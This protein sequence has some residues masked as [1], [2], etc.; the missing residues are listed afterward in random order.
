MP[1]AHSPDISSLNRGTC[2]VHLP[3]SSILLLSLTLAGVC[4]Q[5][6]DRHTHTGNLVLT[7]LRLWWRWLSLVLLEHYHSETWLRAPSSLTVSSCQ[8]LLRS[9]APVLHSLCLAHLAPLVF[10]LAIDIIIV[11]SS[12]YLNS[13]LTKQLSFIAADKISPT[14]VWIT[15]TAC[16]LQLATG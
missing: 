10:P 11:S 8:H 13:I 4:Q 6:P 2:H 15:S 1:L 14:T 16:T 12:I 5:L 3:L 9:I 7:L